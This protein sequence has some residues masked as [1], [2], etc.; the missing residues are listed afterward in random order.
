MWQA[1]HANDRNNWF[2]DSGQAAEPLL[3]FLKPES[4]GGGQ[5]RFWSSNLSKKCEDFGYTFPD[6][7]NSN[8]SIA[9]R[10]RGLY[11]WSIPRI[12][13][14]AKQPPPANMAPISVSNTEFFKPPNA[15]RLNVSGLRDAPDL[16]PRLVSHVQKLQVPTQAKVEKNVAWD[17][18]VDD[19]VER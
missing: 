14:A 18:F 8:I 4:V 11:A 12:P 17:W 15:P 6:L 1:V 3:P 13:G 5:E 19:H 2:S 9:D 16:A 10:F 7:A